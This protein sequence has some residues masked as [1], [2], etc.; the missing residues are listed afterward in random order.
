[1]T[2]SVSMNGVR[3]KVYGH[4]L[5]NPIVDAQP[6]AFLDMAAARH[7]D[8]LVCSPTSLS[9]SIITVMKVHVIGKKNGVSYLI[10][11]LPFMHMI[12]KHRR[13]RYSQQLYHIS[14][15]DLTTV[16]T[17]ETL[18]PMTIRLALTQ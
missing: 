17:K 16:F 10:T 13:T 12:C 7:V 1:M 3:L 18:G 4:Q 11:F 2:I 14:Y 8:V 9:D 6:P 15:N 5:T